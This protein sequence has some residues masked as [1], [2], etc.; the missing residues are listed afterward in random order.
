MSASKKMIHCLK[1]KETNM[2]CSKGRTNILLYAEGLLD[3]R[4]SLALESHMKECS[5]CRKF[6]LYVKESLKS[7]ESEK[8]TVSNP[9]M[10]TRVLNEM[11]K[12]RQP[13]RYIK[14]WVPAFSFVILFILAIIGGIN[15]GKVYSNI[16]RSNNNELQEEMS[17]IDDIEQ[18]Q[19]ENFFMTSN[20]TVDE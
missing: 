19:I 18:E 6:M 14:R 11:G 4:E 10:A 1:G 2:N 3:K 5:D 15:L 13:V 17:Y 7:I 20:I 12:R 16:I 9:F 8:N